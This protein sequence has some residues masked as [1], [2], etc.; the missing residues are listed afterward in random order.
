MCPNA[1]HCFWCFY[2]GAM[3]ALLAAR[4]AAAQL[5]SIG[6]GATLIAAGMS[7]LGMGTWR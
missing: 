5:V 6:A 4:L 1:T 2:T 7:I 3:I